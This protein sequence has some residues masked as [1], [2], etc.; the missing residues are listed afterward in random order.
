M[1]RRFTRSGR[2][3]REYV[4][5]VVIDDAPVRAIGILCQQPDGTWQ[6]R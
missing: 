6:L 3:C 1:V 5:T 4:Q 2:P